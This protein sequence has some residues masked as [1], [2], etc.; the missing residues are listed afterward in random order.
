[1][2]A[3]L[4]L[5]HWGKGFGALALGLALTFAIAVLATVIRWLPGMA[6]LTPLAI[7]VLIGL[8]I[9]NI[10]TLS[11]KFQP[12]VS[13]AGRQL[14]RLAIVLL[15]FQLSLTQLIAIG[16]G[17]LA[18]VTIVVTASFVLICWM[19]SA[20]KVDRKL[21]ELIACGTSV[22]GA[23]AVVAMG[24]VNQSD[25]EDVVYALGSV[26]VFGTVLMFLLPA[27]A[28]TFD[29]NARFFG[30]WA[31]ASIHEVAQVTG[32]AFQLGSVSGEV[33]IIVKLARVLML[34]PLILIFGLWARSLKS[35]ASERASVPAFPVFVLGF[36]LVVV[37]NSVM[38]L[39]T[40]LRTNIMAMTTFLMSMA[41]GALGLQTNFRRLKGKGAR[42][43]M[44][45]A[46][47]TVLIVVLSFGLIIL[48]ESLRS[49]L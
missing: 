34:A 41:L 11:E 17:S 30:I 24:S 7:S 28:Q 25:E 16:L 49:S 40:E 15:G 14:L 27:I 19:G 9:G 35:A 1:M 10:H 48:S 12:G 42:P 8:A 33:G 22:C 18:V 21:S 23:S 31:G 47:G 43:L 3:V 37:L 32:A 45:G 5:P 13:F 26:T 46:A 6:I 39:P 38:P 36:V 2:S 20:F 29:V 4:P 44:L